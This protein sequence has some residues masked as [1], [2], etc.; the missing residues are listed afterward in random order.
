MSEKNSLKSKENANTQR[1]FFV[2]TV[3]FSR[4]SLHSDLKY[5]IKK[6]KTPPKANPKGPHAFQTSW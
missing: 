3:D 4:V 2:D 5:D 6:E 1:L